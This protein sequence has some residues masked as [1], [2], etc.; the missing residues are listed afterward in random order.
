MPRLTSAIVAIVVLT[1]PGPAA[2][3]A[4]PPL[5][6]VVEYPIHPDGGIVYDPLKREADRTGQLERYRSTPSNSQEIRLANCRLRVEVPR[7]AAAYEV[8]PIP[9]ELSWEGGAP[10]FPLAVEVTAF[11]DESR[12]KGRDCHDLNLPGRIDLDVEYLGSITAHL[13]PNGRHNLK[14]DMSD[15]PETYPPFNRRPFVRSGVL[16]AG[17]LVWFKLR[18]TNTG[19]TIL[20]PEGLGG[21]LFYPQLLQKQEDGQYTA[22]GQAYNLYYRDLE[23]LYPGESHE[24]WLHLTSN[25]PGY[26]EGAGKSGTP[27]GFGISPGE[28]MLQLR[29]FA[30][31]YKTSDDFLNIWEGP[32]MYAW[33]MPFSVEAQAR[34]APVLPGTKTL[35]DGGDPDKI[36]RFIHTFEEF[37][38]SFDCH[39]SAPADG[40]S[41]IGGTL[42]LQVAPWTSQVVAKLI[43]TGPVAIATA[44]IPIE[45]DAT[46]LKVRFNPNPGTCMVRDGRR[47]PII[48]SQT[49][50]DMRTNVQIGPFPEKHIVDRLR[51]MMDCGINVIAPTNM[52]WLYDDMRNPKSNYQGDAF[53]Y[54]LDVARREGMTVE[55]WGTYPFDRANVRDIAAWITGESIPIERYTLGKSAISLTEPMLPFANSVAW[56]YQFHRWGDLYLQVERGDVPISVEDTRGWMRQDVNVRHPMGDQTVKAFRKWVRNKYRTIEAANKAWGSSFGSFDEIDPEKDRA[57]NRFGHRWEYTDPKHAFRDWN[58]AVCDLDEF[59]TELRVSNYRDTLALVRREIPQAVICLRTE[60]GNVLVDGIDP[61]DPNPHMRHVYYSQR[62]CA[63]IAGMLQ[64]S[65]LIRYHSDYTT[66]PY[67]PSELRRLVRMAVEQGIIPSY[68]PQ[69]DN[70]R[71]IAINERYGTEYQIHYNLPEPRKGYMMHCLTALYP[72]FT[73]VHESGGIPGILWEDYQCDGFAT[74]TQKREMRLFKEKLIEAMSTPEGQKALAENVRMPSQEWRKGARAMWSYKLPK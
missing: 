74:E 11:E 34:E 46:S 5:A 28:Y 19:N 17:D 9:Y 7:K 33:E 57:P 6:P 32:E 56:L 58:Q 29:L 2:L 23:Y 50:A 53:K 48:T 72:W 30:R 8:I 31:C 14:A 62:R 66:V 73:A 69:F 3:G 26:M 45:I 54:V 64:K 36:T 24:I 59:R 38:S 51:E 43:A 65:G 25:M 16:E 71:D 63:A 37:M 40:T 52:P 61:T 49:M 39:L 35:V 67:T 4:P 47:I 21:C 44:G 1:T 68:F 13:R 70:M 42:H 10:A 15:Q 22:V 41:R 20:D 27:Q 18:Y 12:R 55:G 60:G